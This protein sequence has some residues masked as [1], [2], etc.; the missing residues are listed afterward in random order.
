MRALCFAGLISFGLNAKAQDAAPAKNLDILKILA[1]RIATQVSFKVAAG[2][3][4]FVQVNPKEASWYIES[5]L[6]DGFRSEHIGMAGTDSA[7]YIAAFSLRDSHIRY[8]N[9]RGD[10]VF[11]E[12]L[13]DRRVGLSLDVKLLRRIEQAPVLVQQF[14]EEFTD[15]ISIAEIDQV[16]NPLV[17]ASKG[18]LESGGF[19]STFLEPIVLLGSIGVAVFLL[20]HVRS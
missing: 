9:P 6:Y 7:G 10:N 20:F 3:T 5:G 12:R 17:D 14:D 18:T 2:N 1:Q 4:V 16:E 19:F 11:G 8:E 15:T 13:A